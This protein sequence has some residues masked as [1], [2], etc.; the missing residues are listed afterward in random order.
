[1]L[2]TEVEKATGL[3]LTE[4]QYRVVHSYYRKA[5]GGK[6]TKATIYRELMQHGAEEFTRKHKGFS[7]ARENS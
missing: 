7:E 1:M 2:K 6:I 4:E 5:Y 3:Q